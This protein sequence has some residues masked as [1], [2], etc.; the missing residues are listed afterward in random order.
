VCLDAAC[1]RGANRLFGIY[2]VELSPAFK[3]AGLRED[4]NPRTVVK[5]QGERARLTPELPERSRSYAVSGSTK[6]S[7]FV[8]GT[9]SSRRVLK[10]S[11]KCSSL[12]ASA[13]IF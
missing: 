8:A 7:F 12:L 5:E 10:R 4:K 3:I 11:V 6:F 9:N 2:G 13:N 1:T